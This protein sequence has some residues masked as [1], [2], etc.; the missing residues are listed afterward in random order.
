MNKLGLKEP[1]CE[2]QRAFLK[3]AR[4]PQKLLRF[5]KNALVNVSQS[6]TV[7]QEFKTV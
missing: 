1:G 3:K 7:K 6:R 4:D 5:Q 2:N